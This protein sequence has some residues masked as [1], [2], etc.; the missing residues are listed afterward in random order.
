MTSGCACSHC[1]VKGK[2]VPTV[3][4]Y[5]TYVWECD[6]CGLE[7]LPV[8]HIHGE[9]MNGQDCPACGLWVYRACQRCKCGREF[10]SKDW[11]DCP[12]R[13]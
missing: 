6:Q 11:A 4:G 9:A 7:F 2:T 13:P 1:R 8:T 3:S 10:T 12:W 5:S